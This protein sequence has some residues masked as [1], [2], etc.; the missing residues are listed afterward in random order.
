MLVK[1]PLSG[2]LVPIDQVPDPVFAGKMVGDG[3]SVDP[4]SAR[5]LAPCDGRVVQL[6]SSGH[7]L[8]IASETGIEL[9]IHIGLDTVDLKGR[10]FSPRV[11]VGDAVRTGDLLVEFDPAMKRLII[12]CA[13]LFFWRKS[14]GGEW[15]WSRS[16]R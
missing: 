8:T 1:A 10:G 7:A 9:M 2:V 5:L 4:V 15:N 14:S 6:H 12:S 3:V 11:R 13:C 16:N